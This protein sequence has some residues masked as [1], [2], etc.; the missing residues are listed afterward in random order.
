MKSSHVH[1]IIR[2]SAGSG[3][4]HQLT[5]RYLALLAAG[6]EPSTILATTFTRK[7]AGEIFNRILVRLATAAESDEQAGQLARQLGDESLSR[8]R[9]VGLLRRMTKAIHRVRV[10]TLDSF[11]V[12]LAG[13]F[14][15]ELGLPAGWSI[16]E[17]ADDQLLRDEALERLL[18]RDNSQVDAVLPLL[19][20][21]EWRR[22]V[23]G[24]L[25]Q[26][27]AVYYGSYRVATKSAWESL[28][29]P[30]PP[31]PTQVA[32]AL[33]HLREFDFAP[34]GHKR[35]F[36]AQQ[37][38][39]NAFASED[40]L[41]FISK[42]LGGSIT[43]GK[44]QYFGKEIPKS[45]SELYGT[46]LA[47]ARSRILQSLAEQTKATW[48]LLDS[49]D[50]ELKELKQS[51]GLLRFD[52]VTQTLVELRTSSG[53]SLESL[54]FRLDGE[55]QHLLL[56]EF[57]DTSLSQWRVLEPIARGIALSGNESKSFFC[58]GDVKQAIYG[59]RG[60]MAEIFQSLHTSL[61]LPEPSILTESRRSA[62]PII[63]VVNYVFG[64]LE[65]IELDEKC[66]AGLSAWAQRF[67]PHTTVKKDVPGY[68]MLCTGPAQDGR[69][70]DVQ[71]AEHCR[72]VA[73]KVRDLMTS[74]GSHSV[75]ILCRRNVTVARMVFELRRLN[76]EASEEGGNP[77]TDSA[78]VEVMLSLFT[79]ADH[80][81]NSV[82]WFHLKNSPLKSH[83][84]A[85]D[86]PDLLAISLRRELLSD[87]YGEFAYRWARR[88]APA[89]DRRELSRLQQLVEM[90]YDHQPRSTLRTA[91]FV[92][93][94]RQERVPDPSS[95][96]VRVMTFHAAKGLQFDIVVLPELETSLQG[97]PPALVVG[98]DPATLDASFVCRRAGES[99][100]A[101]LT[102][103]ERE[104]FDDDVDR[105]VE[106][107]LSLL[108]VAMTRAIHAM[109]MFIPGPRDRNVKDA[110]YNLLIKKLA[111]DKEYRG[112]SCL[113]EIG[114]ADWFKRSPAKS[115]STVPGPPSK[116]SPI[117][118]C[119]STSDRRRGLEF[120]T[121]ASQEGH[122][123]ISLSKLFDSR[124]RIGMATGTLFHA[125]FALIGWLDDGR[126]EAT[127]LQIAADKLRTS[128]PSELWSTVPQ[129]MTRFLDYLA[130]PG[131][132]AVLSRTAYSDLKNQ[133]F[134]AALSTCWT[135]SLKPVVNQE[136]RFLVR[137]E[138]KFWS[139]SLDRVVWMMDGNRKVAADV[140][141]FKSDEIRPG[142][143]E[144]IRVR[145]DFYRPQAIAYRQAVARFAK[146]PEDRVSV[147]LVFTEP[148]IIETV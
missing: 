7:A 112:D 141:D 14:S 111:R 86:N 10:G 117:Q 100:R 56:D 82:A 37:N 5:N 61:E 48:R 102:E 26:A 25:Q 44:T 46:L 1:E 49:F 110:W 55:I 66:C 78:A 18:A 24:Q 115:E 120:V 140:L 16:G 104:V 15:L 130:K 88:L 6:V 134:P 43:N 54:A 64:G 139:G 89:C 28:Y 27:I 33:D 118:F 79:I 93:R 67:E 42:G 121:P 125:W 95:A 73:E 3:K 136:R 51:T 138:D 69:A 105:R 65:Q 116:L 29:L 81:G 96:R 50:C 114:D 60:G 4:T 11:F 34:C 145:T 90:A 17:E 147:R 71:R 72:H 21:G 143:A 77:L 101:L 45:A 35:F 123:K 85:E 75:G 131:V 94:V 39:I 148:G 103:A 133:G 68:S 40:W 128:L 74:I 2:A 53:I 119:K 76:I 38:D 92:R 58:V 129:L 83:L 36:T 62:Q 135:R 97:R 12:A 87:G 8:D 80:P 63:D 107:S 113:F 108:Y 32:S 144:A 84:T 70:L 59:W 57:Q 132:A 9:F 127:A 22:S 124:D 98:R 41:T 146:L 20:K 122:G 23:H 13:S 137:G 126:P 31:D 99:V 106:E 109:Y 47:H 52:E 19:N 142:D 91:D 30:A